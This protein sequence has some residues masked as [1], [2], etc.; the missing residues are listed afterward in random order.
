[1]G[2]G[3]LLVDF[4]FPPRCG[5]CT[6]RGDWFCAG[7]RESVRSAPAAGCLRCGRLTTILPCPLCDEVPPPLDGLFAPARLAGPVREAVHR[8]K[9]GDRPQ[10]AAALADLWLDWQPPVE[11]AVL[12]PVPLGPR[13]LRRRGYNQALELAQRLATDR[14][15]ACWAGALVRVIETGTQVGRGGSDRRQA[16][17][18]AFAWRG[19]QAPAVVIVVDDV[20]TTGATL[21][22]CGRACRGAGAARVYGLALAAG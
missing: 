7:C 17:Q 15:L 12:V 19:G 18:G 22:E 13:R 16:L 20:V 6:S 1:M 8:L 14:G 4:F 9:Y 21:M 5:G 10:L 3:G 2:A 11:D